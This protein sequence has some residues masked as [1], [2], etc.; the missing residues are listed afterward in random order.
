MLTRVPS[1]INLL[2]L[3][4]YSVF[5]FNVFQ[6][7]VTFLPSFSTPIMESLQPSNTDCFNCINMTLALNMTNITTTN[8]TV[9]PQPELDEDKLLLNLRPGLY[10][11]RIYSY[12]PW[13]CIGLPANIIACIVWMQ[14]QVCFYKRVSFSQNGAQLSDEYL[15][16]Q[17]LPILDG[18]YIHIEIRY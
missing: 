6:G 17:F 12:I 8:T 16:M 4:I 13:Y 7:L 5:G 3:H 11:A 2:S 14:R 1:R 15:I 10:Y 9:M 18:V